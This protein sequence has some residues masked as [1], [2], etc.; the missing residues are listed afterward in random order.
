MN[1]KIRFPASCTRL[2]GAEC[3]AAEGG[4]LIRL[5]T[6]CYLTAEMFLPKQHSAAQPTA[7]DTE[8]LWL[9][10]E[11]GDIVKLGYGA[12]TYADG[13]VYRMPRQDAGG[14]WIVSFFYNA[15]DFFDSIGL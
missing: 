11:H 10:R 1:G 4:C 13:Y 5:S 6:W 8:V 15:G 9:Q 2:D 7:A 12:Y 14:R 3:S